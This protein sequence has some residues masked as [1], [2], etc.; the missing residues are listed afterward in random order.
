MALGADVLLTGQTSIPAGQFFLGPM[1]TA[2]PQGAMVTGLRFPRR[3]RA[4]I[5]F[6]EIAQRHGDYAMAAVATEITLDADGRCS[7]I[8]LA[9]GGATTAPTRLDLDGLAGRR[10]AAAEVKEAVHAALL[11]LEMME[12]PNT[13]GTYRRR[14]ATALAVQAVAQ[15]RADAETLH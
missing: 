9:V 2:L 1:M 7:D 14:A 10:L 4:G 12:D 13:T 11:P 5:G 8:R 3:P 6:V 15:A